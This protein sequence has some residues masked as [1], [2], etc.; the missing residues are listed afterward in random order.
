MGNS[1][2][3]HEQNGLNAIDDQDR[4]EAG[5]WLGRF[6]KSVIY[7][8]IEHKKPYSWLTK[9]GGKSKPWWG[10]ALADA[11]LKP[12]EREEKKS[13]IVI[14]GRELKNAILIADLLK[15]NED[16]TSAKLSARLEIMQAQSILNNKINAYL[17]LR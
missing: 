7:I 14:R 15:E 12:A 11:K 13:A 4:I 9:H 10:Y 5:Y 2:R 8:L 17:R 6:Y 1:Q 3:K 16:V